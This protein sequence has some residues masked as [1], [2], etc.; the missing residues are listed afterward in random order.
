MRTESNSDL[1]KIDIKD[2]DYIPS[3][4]RYS[5][6]SYVTHSG[7]QKE[8]PDI[9]MIGDSHADHY[10]YY[11]NNINKLPVYFKVLHATFAYGPNFYCLKDKFFTDTTVRKA[12]FNAYTDILNKLK[13]GDKV[14]L[15]NRW[16]VQYNLYMKEFSLKDTTENYKKFLLDDLAFEI[17]KRKIS[18]SILC[19]KVLLQ[20]KLL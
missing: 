15:T 3:V 5:E 9:F 14:I 1:Y 20:A 11:V 10:R 6:L 17:D 18:I 13:Q 12:Y 7:Y 19:P 8:K 2:P 4:T 16:D